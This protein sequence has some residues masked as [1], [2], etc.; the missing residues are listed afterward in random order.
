MTLSAIGSLV[1]AEERIPFYED[2]LKESDL[3][4]FIEEAESFLQES[5]DAM[6][7]PRVAMDL[8][9]VGKAANQPK[10]VDQATDFTVPCPQSLPSLQF[11]SSFDQGSPRMIN[12]LKIKADQGDLGSKDFAVSYCRTLLFVAKIHGP[13]LLKDASLRIRLF[14][15][16]LSGSR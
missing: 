9:M 10:V 12:L 7:A 5:P 4:G 8:L 3:R 16:Y 14:V 6:E 2:F 15:G 1:F 13:T 11:I